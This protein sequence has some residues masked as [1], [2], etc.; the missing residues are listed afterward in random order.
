M[1]DGDSS[2]LLMESESPLCAV[3]GGNPAVPA[4]HT[5]DWQY[6]VGVS[7]RRLSAERAERI[8][9]TSSAPDPRL[10]S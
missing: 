5:G 7:G 2:I 3:G 6:G 4:A 9:E 10:R 1:R 8:L